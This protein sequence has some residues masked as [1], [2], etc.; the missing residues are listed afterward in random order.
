LTKPGN[1][2]IIEQIQKE[3]DRRWEALLKKCA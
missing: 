3:T 1:E 2:G